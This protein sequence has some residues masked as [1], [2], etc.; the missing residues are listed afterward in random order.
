MSP[1]SVF[2]GCAISGHRMLKP[3]ALLHS[4]A[5]FAVIARTWAKR[6]YG[7]PVNHGSATSIDTAGT[8]SGGITLCTAG[9]LPLGA[10]AGAVVVVVAPGAEDEA[11][12]ADGE[13][14][15][16]EAQ[17]LCRPTVYWTFDQ[18]SELCENCLLVASSN[19]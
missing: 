17:T 6:A 12:G 7:V 8:R 10:A 16:T 4:V 15:G 18:M 2:C 19:S 3:N 14:A 5:P 11:A 1:A 13:L 9:S